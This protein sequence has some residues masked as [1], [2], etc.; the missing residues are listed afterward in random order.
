VLG[1][2]EYTLATSIHR[3]QDS[4]LSSQISS[5]SLAISSLSSED[6]NLSSQISSLENINLTAVA[7]D[8]NSH[9]S[10]IFAG[11]IVNAMSAYTPKRDG[12]FRG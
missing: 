9:I 12:D 7:D 10:G 11:E 4:G 1:A 6:Q 3:Q 5:Q 2:Y 8:A